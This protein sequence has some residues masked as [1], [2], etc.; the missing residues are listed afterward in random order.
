M[1][2]GRA[3]Q[4]EEIWEAT[5]A[6]CDEQLSPTSIY[7]LLHVECHRLFPDEAFA[8]LFQDSGRRSVPPRIVAVVMVLQRLEGLSDREAVDRFT[9]DVRWKYAAGGLGLEYPGFVHTVLVDMRA[10][11]RASNAPNRIF[12]TVLEVAKSAGMVGRRRVLDSTPLYDAVATQDTVTMIRAS[13]RG[14]LGVSDATLAAEL[15]SV[16]KRDD[17]Y[18]KAGKPVCAWEDKAAREALIDE[19][20]RDA[21]AVLAHLEGHTLAA[22]VKQ[23]A[24]LVA[25]VVG[26]DLEQTTDGL[27]RIARRVAPDRVI[28]TVDPQTRHGHKT[29]ARGF[30][31]YKGHIAIDPDAELI[32]AAE[33]TAGHIGDGSVTKKLLEEILPPAPSPNNDTSHAADAPLDAP[34]A[35]EPSPPT[36]A[37]TPTALDPEAEIITA[38]VTAGHV[39]DESVTE[40]RL[41]EIP[42]PAPSLNHDASLPADASL[43]APAAPEPSPPT[44]A[45]TPPEA[46]PPIEPI[47]VYGDASYG[48]AEVLIHLEEAGAVA[49]VKVQA[50]TAPDGRLTKEAFQI[51]LANDTVRCPSGQLVQI[52]RRSDGSGMANFGVACNQ[53]PLA[54]S[55][56][57]S[58]EG[59]SIRVH[60]HERQLLDARERQKNPIWRANYRATRPKVERKLAH[61]MY[62]RHGGRRARMRGTERVAQDFVLLCAADNLR[63][64]AQLG[65]HSTHA[66]GEVAWSV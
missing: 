12:N 6:H 32:T 3:P 18:A 65:V 54:P 25:T 14:L 63:R 29:A 45:P 48:T 16:L 34:A 40:K 64:L 41:E 66:S 7:R 26:Q 22:D 49:N 13:I 56:S 36:D 35:P 61:L 19:L 50:P 20:A 57:T 38:E 37:P 21:H 10:R 44:D 17:D 33:V 52:R 46:S 31:G 27:F 51:D 8:D 60:A 4:Q 1:T 2:L 58:K 43:D 39:V 23:A 9:F 30:D 24:A 11:L 15:R 47:D 62:R 5:T 28:S 59:R 55:C 42:P 53:C